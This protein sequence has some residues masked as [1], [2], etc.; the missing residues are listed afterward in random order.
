GGG[1]AGGGMGGAGGWIGAAASIA[2]SF[3][4]NGGAFGAGTHA[5]A[6][7]GAFTNGIYD[8]PT[9]F[10]FAKGGGFAN[11]VMGEAGPEAVMPLQRDSSG[12]LGV[13]LNGGAPVGGGTVVSINIEV[14]NNGD[15]TTESSKGGDNESNWKDL[16][17]RVKSLVQ[18]EIVKQKRPGGMLR[19]TNQ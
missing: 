8:S 17:N 11:G 9:Y 6:N 2:S 14:N 18:E 4:A 10:K 15:T 13:A 16:S 5:F 3:F 7:G 1:G 19:S 12:R